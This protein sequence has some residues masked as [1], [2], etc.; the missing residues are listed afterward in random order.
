MCFGCSTIG[1]LS[2][3]ANSEGFQCDEDHAI[4]R[5]YSGVSNDFRFIRGD[6]QDKGVVFWDLPFSLVADTLVLPYTCYAQIRYGNLCDKA[7]KNSNNRNQAE[8][9]S[10]ARFMP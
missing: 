6:Y 1:T 5:I 2:A 4:T 7:S 10:G 9:Y 3:S 8:I